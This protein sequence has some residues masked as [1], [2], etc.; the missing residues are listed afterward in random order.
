[1]ICTSIQHKTYPQILDILNAPEVEMAEIRLD[2]CELSDEEIEDLFG[3]SDTP[4]VA[5]CRFG[6]LPWEE[7]ERRLSLAVSAGARFA[8]LEIEAPASV[9]KRFQKLCRI[10]GTEII[11]S[12]HDFDSTPDF[13]L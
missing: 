8:D 5:T 2:L 11:R 6:A 1:M 13:F 7:V 10:N 9:S 3:C 12:F 4:L